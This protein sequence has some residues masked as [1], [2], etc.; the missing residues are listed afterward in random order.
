MSRWLR[1][2]AI[3]SS[4]PLDDCSRCFYCI[5]SNMVRIVLVLVI[6]SPESNE[7]ASTQT[8]LL[9]Y[10]THIR[11][12]E[13]LIHYSK[14][15][16]IS[17]SPWYRSFPTSCRQWWGSYSRSPS[18]RPRVG[19]CRW[20][21]ATCGSAACASPWR[22]VSASCSNSSCPC[23]AIHRSS[24]CIWNEHSR[25]WAWTGTVTI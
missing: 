6:L 16:S 11:G 8:L 13:N 5:F 3:T 2:G 7:V 14:C 4:W 19:V 1:D 24:S 12:T 15:V 9:W 21:E 23:Q 10:I 22:G 18:T 17:P 25:R 20:N